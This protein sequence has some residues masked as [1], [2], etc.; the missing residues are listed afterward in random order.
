[1][2]VR[3]LDIGEQHMVQDSPNRV[4]HLFHLHRSLQT[5][6]RLAPF[7]SLREL[8]GGQGAVRLKATYTMSDRANVFVWAHSQNIA[9]YNGLL[10]TLLIASERRLIEACLA[11]EREAMRRIEVALP[12][13]S[14]GIE[15]P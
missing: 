14:V 10:K 8:A 2:R 13:R 3:L 12:A 11:E 9:R 7:P 1:M 6:D 4:G 15:I 5:T